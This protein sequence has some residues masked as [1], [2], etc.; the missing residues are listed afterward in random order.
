MTEKR[1]DNCSR[2][3]QNN[4][5]DILAEQNEDS[6]VQRDLCKL[7]QDT[8]N[9]TDESF[10]L[11][12]ENM[13]DG[14]SYHKMVYDGEGNPTDYVFLEINSAFEEQ[15]GL[16]KEN[17]IGKSVLEVLPDTENYWI[18]IYGKVS[19]SGVPVKFENYSREL[20]KWY[21]VS[22]YSP[23]VNYFAV[24]SR[25]ITESKEKEETIRKINLG[26][27][28]KIIE[29]TLQLQVL[30]SELEETNAEL[31]EINAMLEEEISKRQ[32]V[33]E[34]L[35]KFNEQLENKVIERTNQLQE[36]N[37][38]LEEEITDKI[39]AENELKMEKYFT[40]AVIDSVPG[41]LYLYDDQG[42]LVRWNKKHEELTGYS[43]EE[44]S[45][46]TVLDW[47]R[48]DEKSIQ[49]ITERIQKTLEDGFGEAE[50]NLQRKDGTIIPMYFTAVRLDL[51]GR[52]YFTGIGIDITDRKKKEDENLYL[53]YHD[54]LTGLYN[55]RFYEEGIKRLDTKRNLPISI[56]IGDVNG[57]KLVND[58]FGHDKG[59]ELLQKAA[60]VIQSACR[61]DDIVARWGGD[62]FVI[63]LPKTNTKEA[64]EIVD[65]IKELYSDVY[66]NAIRVSISFGWD[67]KRETDQDILKVLKSAED[68]MYQH[69]IIEN[70]SMRDNT[71]S[72]I[73]RTLHEKNP[74]EEQH[75]QRV[76]EIC[77]YIGK[78]MGLSEIEVS[79]LK[80]VG[81]LHDIGKIA[82]EEG[83]LNKP[84]K[85]TEQEKS[86][87]NRHPDI[88]YRILSS[89][90]SMLD[91]ADC[92]LAHHERWDGAGYPKGLK[93][94]AIPMVA[95]IIALA[96]TYDAMTSERSYRKALSEEEALAEI[97]KNIGTQFDPEIA[98][99]FIE[100][101]LD[102]Q[103]DSAIIRENI[104]Q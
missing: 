53:S 12:F 90:F 9:M 3:D 77:Q 16:R 33:E 47:F 89:S 31:E 7:K 85:L 86:E 96:D 84:G 30:N 28:N 65:R 97:R 67:T 62:E 48:E 4:Y 91:L 64:E 88:G 95:R 51:D 11:L 76:S 73:I 59:D 102:K 34:E 69:K 98:R 75:S 8:P 26:L 35:N 21:A 27:E 24:I 99:I 19:L 46:I 1:D 44:L 72:T 70:E 18:E 78:A 25:D 101:L 93:G 37:A 14:F 82:I 87:I 50:A 56:I 41:F 29:R 40:D 63:L 2:E 92:I 61:T 36:M 23:K 81:L 68:Y 57:L 80:V 13:M 103:L 83:I 104:L 94:D 17:L 66:V 60:M 45:N 5:F 100:K 52:T 38:I 58:A 10:R 54:V 20:C 42:K 79:R 22:A 74:R 43:S 15:T 6:I 55:R 71:I 39:Q 32:K 49:D